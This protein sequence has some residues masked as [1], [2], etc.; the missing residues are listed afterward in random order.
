[1]ASKLLYKSLE[2]QGVGETLAHV[3]VFSKACS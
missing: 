2:P 1:M 3:V